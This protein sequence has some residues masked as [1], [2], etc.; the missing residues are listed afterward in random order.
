MVEHPVT[1]RSSN[2]GGSRFFGMEFPLR[3][4]IA[5]GE[6]PEQQLLRCSLGLT[7]TAQRMRESRAGMLVLAGVADACD[8]TP[9]QAESQSD[10]RSPATEPHQHTARCNS[11][12]WRAGGSAGTEVVASKG[13]L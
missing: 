6:F 10:Q 13:P 11:A 9:D 2:V 12:A 5:E 7:K 1:K 3:T 8:A 4:P